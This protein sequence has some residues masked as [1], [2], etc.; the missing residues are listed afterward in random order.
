MPRCPWQWGL[1]V[2]KPIVSAMKGS[3]SALVTRCYGPVET[4][5]ESCMG[6]PRH[7]LYRVV[8]KPVR[9]RRIS[10]TRLSFNFLSVG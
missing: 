10:N 2:I 6:M 4:F 9:V 3:V 7:C 5:L 8:Q 1:F